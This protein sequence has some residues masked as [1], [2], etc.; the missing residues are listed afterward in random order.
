MNEMRPLVLL[1]SNGQPIDRRVERVLAGLVP[2]LRRRFPT[3]QDEAVLAEVVEEAGRRIA[4]REEL[5][6]PIERI[7]G[8]AWVTVRSVATSYLR[9]P[10]TRLIQKTLEPEASEICLARTATSYGAPEEVERGILL[11]EVL[12]TLSPA[13]RMVCLWKTAGFTSEEIAAWQGRTVGAVDTSFSRAKQRIRHA[14]A[15][16]APR[17]ARVASVGRR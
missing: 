12:E 5:H 3:L 17:G 14:L 13:D 8:Y 7:H 16:S 2:K 10:A 15:P 6:G 1:G 9:R 4:A 11:R